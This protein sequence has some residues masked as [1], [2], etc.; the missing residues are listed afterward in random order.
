MDDN[1]VNL[2][3]ISEMLKRQGHKI[4]TATNGRQAVDLAATAHFDIIMMDVSMPVMDGREATR[5]IRQSGKSVNSYIM[6]ITALVDA[7]VPDEFLRDGMDSILGKPVSQRQLTDALRQIEDRMSDEDDEEET[8]PL[9][10]V[11]EPEGSFDF[12]QLCG[13]VGD[14]MAIQLVT[15][16]VSDVRK[17]IDALENRTASSADVIHHAVGP[18][19]FI[20]WTTLSSALKTTELAL[21]QNRDDDA[22]DMMGDLKR[23]LIE[24]EQVATKVLE[25]PH[26]S[27]VRPSMMDH[28]PH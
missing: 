28:P 25:A 26:G 5:R 21:R 4:S 8:K 6:G 19:G 11:P 10:Q 20:G 12:E 16:T 17:A 3:L 7:V 1:Q 9:N 15:E 27:D 23:Y 13:M 24:I 22:N 2:R 18:T 14:D